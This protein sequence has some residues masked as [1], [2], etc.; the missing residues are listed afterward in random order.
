MAEPVTAATFLRIYAV[1][2]GFL[3][4]DY[5]VAM[6]RSSMPGPCFSFAP[7]LQVQMKPLYDSLAITP[8]Y[9]SHMH[10]GSLLAKVRATGS[11]CVYNI[12]YSR[13]CVSLPQSGRER[14]AEEQYAAARAMRPTE[15]VT[16]VRRVRERPQIFTTC[17]LREKR[18]SHNGRGEGLL[19]AL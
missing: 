4:R 14:G 12:G 18:K 6:P 19:V 15:H 16:I 11:S 13:P 1:L 10:L 5:E 17:A 2:Q 8:T 9:E 7:L 3:S